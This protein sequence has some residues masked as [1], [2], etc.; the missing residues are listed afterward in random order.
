MG[1]AEGYRRA[2]TEAV[3]IGAPAVSRKSE[4]SE[5]HIIDYQKSG[6]SNWAYI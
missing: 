4:I 6:C 2:S 3:G 1:R 5:P